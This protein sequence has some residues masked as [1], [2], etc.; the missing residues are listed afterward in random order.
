MRCGGYDYRVFPSRMRCG[1][2]NFTYVF[3]YLYLFILI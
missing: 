2:Y 3:T 1:G